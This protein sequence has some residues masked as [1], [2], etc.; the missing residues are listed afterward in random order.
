MS[1]ESSAMD[2][3]ESSVNQVEVV[4]E[5]L[6]EEEKQAGSPAVGA[7]SADSTVPTEIEGKV[8]EDVEMQ[9]LTLEDPAPSDPT[10]AAA[11][12][13]E[14]PKEE[15]EDLLALL[16][17]EVAQ[18]VGAVVVDRPPH[19]LGFEKGFHLVIAARIAGHRV[20]I[21]DGIAPARG[22]PCEW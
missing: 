8:A 6:V 16:V 2:C 18:Q 19:P 13:T 7:K 20:L 9:D 1:A 3:A 17:I 14:E 10:E 21:L 4:P 11:S 5:A 22:I 15:V 12:V